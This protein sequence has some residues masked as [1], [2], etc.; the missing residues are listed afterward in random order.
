[1]LQLVALGRDV[2]IDTRLILK[3]LEAL[4]P[5][6]PEHPSLAAKDD[7]S[8]GLEDMLELWVID[9]GPFWRTA[10]CIPPTAALM[11]DPVFVK[12]RQ[13]GSGGAFTIESLQA[14]RAYCISQLRIFFGI[15]ETM[16]KDGRKWVL[17]SN[18][19]PGLADLHAC[20]VYDWGVN[21][22]T[23]MLVDKDDAS[24]SSD[25][26]TALGEQEFPNVHAWVARFRDICDQAHSDNTGAKSLAEGPEAEDEIVRTIFSSTYAEPERLP[27][28]ESDVLGLK[29][30]QRVS[31]V[32]SDFGFTHADAGVLVGLST[33]EVTIQIS[34]EDKHDLRLHFPRINF[35]VTP[36]S[37]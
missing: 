9:G 37:A 19:L 3:K 24:K 2:Y 27:F 16:L 22:V 23:D 32:P 5:D 21:M 34:R 30:D 8:K 20:W 33:N 18:K 12:D 31:V 4:I 17:G 10:G 13:D 15:M 29:R 7:F 35:Q 36:A 28:D 6:S 25:M 1:M 26:S 14:G 11:K